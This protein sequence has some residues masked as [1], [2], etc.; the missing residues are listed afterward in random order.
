[1]SSLSEP[2]EGQKLQKRQLGSIKVKS[3]DVEH[4]NALMDELFKLFAHVFGNHWTKR[5]GTSDKA[6]DMCKKWRGV[7]QEMNIEDVRLGYR[8]LKEFHN[9]A[10]DIME[11]E[12][13]KLFCERDV[14][15]FIKQ[16]QAL[17]E[18]YRDPLGP[19]RN[20]RTEKIYAEIERRK[21][22]GEAVQDICLDMLKKQPWK[23]HERNEQN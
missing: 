9:R 5:F 14:K 18:R 19:L 7:V 23:N 11:V 16:Q 4:Q 3:L 1:M 21:R 22:N 13:F 2:Q 12:N 17:K 20:E 15:N 8:A 6:S 10:M